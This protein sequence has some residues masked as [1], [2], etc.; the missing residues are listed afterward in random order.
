M[1][2]H[3]AQATLQDAEITRFG[4]MRRALMQARDE[5]QRRWGADFLDLSGSAPVA[6]WPSDDV[7]AGALAVGR[8]TR[9]YGAPEGTPA[10]RAAAARY[11][12]RST[13]VPFGPEN[14]LITTGG[15]GGLSAT[16]ATVCQPGYGVAVA[17]PYY[18]AHPSLVELAG[19]RTVRVTAGGDGRI[20]PSAFAGHEPQALLFANPANPT[21]VTYNRRQVAA[22][23]T[24]LPAGAPIVVDE[25]YADYVYQPGDFASVAEVL[26]A[27]DAARWAVVR[28]ASKTLGRPGLRIGMVLGPAGLVQEIGDRVAAMTGAASRPAQEAF[29]A[30]LAEIAEVD[31]ARPYRRR[32]DVAMALCRRLGLTVQ[33]PQGAYF[34]WVDGPGA[35]QLDTAVRLCVEA[36]VFA[37]PGAYFG[38]TSHLRVS[39]AA[40]LRSLES[41]LERIAA[42]LTARRTDDGRLPVS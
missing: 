22:L 17:T 8:P 25:V 10:A 14:V 39:L 9:G 16:L 36:G 21:G 41:G 12:S 27:D 5:G 15:L 35:G 3:P 7:V 33:P 30:G 28:S 29:V 23:A 19:G 4:A 26:P 40:P 18:H 1:R 38:A 32:L 37:W 6:A 42:S 24:G 20:G 2:E 13:G 11:F 34:L 31:H